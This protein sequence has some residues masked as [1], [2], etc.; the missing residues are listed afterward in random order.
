[1]VRWS[2]PTYVL[3]KRYIKVAQ[4]SVYGCKRYDS[5]IVLIDERR[6]VIIAI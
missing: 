6:V 3:Y 2:L 4:D 1:M 5:S